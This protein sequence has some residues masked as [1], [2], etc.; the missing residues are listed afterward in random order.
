[1]V[2]S[3]LLVDDVEAHLW[4]TA[5]LVYLS[6]PQSDIDT[7]PSIKQA[8]PCHGVFITNVPSVLNTSSLLVPIP[9]I[10]S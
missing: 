10:L 3:M 5:Q 4:E 6:L 9:F 1:M 2:S 8:L 7:V